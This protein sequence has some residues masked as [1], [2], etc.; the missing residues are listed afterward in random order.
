MPNV[1][2]VNVVHIRVRALGEEQM[3]VAIRCFVQLEQ[4]E[5]NVAF[6]WRIHSLQA[7][8]GQILHAPRADTR[9]ELV[10]QLKHILAFGVVN[11]DRRATQQLAADHAVVALT[12]QLELATGTGRSSLPTTARRLFLNRRGGGGR[13]DCIVVVTRRTHLH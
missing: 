4:V 7:G 3:L 2:F 12:K 8:H 10:R 1:D 9:V 11:R 5:T 6:A 13:T